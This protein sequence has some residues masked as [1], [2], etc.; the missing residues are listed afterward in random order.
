MKITHNVKIAWNP[1]WLELATVRAVYR[2]PCDLLVPKILYNRSGPRG[3]CVSLCVCLPVS[4]S[5]CV[6]LWE[7][8]TDIERET[9]RETETE[10][11]ETYIFIIPNTR[12]FEE[13]ERERVIKR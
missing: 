3:V 5:L 13:G 9:D 11:E 6:S 1:V 7:R 12:L 8:E 2:Q 4:V 10:T